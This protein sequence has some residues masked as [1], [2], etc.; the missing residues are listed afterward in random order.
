[1]YYYA[2]FYRHITIDFAILLTSLANN[3][4]NLRTERDGNDRRDEGNCG[5]RVDYNLCDK[6]NGMNRRRK[7]KEH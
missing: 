1:M 3:T 6:K 7:G 4:I 5:N 2:Q